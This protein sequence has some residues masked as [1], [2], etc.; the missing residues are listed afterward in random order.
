[1]LK[2][3]EAPEMGSRLVS[4]KTSGR[5]SDAPIYCFTRLV[6][7]FVLIVPSLPIEPQEPIGLVLDGLPD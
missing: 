2:V 7:F 3:V 5:Q 4:V 1:M 6:A